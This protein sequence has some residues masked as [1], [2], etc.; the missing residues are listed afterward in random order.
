[1]VTFFFYK[2]FTTAEML[3]K[4]S[5]NYQYSDGYVIVEDF[6]LDQD[7]VIINKDSKPN[8]KLLHGKIVQ[9]PSSA[10]DVVKKIQE[11]AVGV[12]PKYIMESVWANKST[13]GVQKAFIIY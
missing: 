13:G 5:S 11:C 9:F 7:I 6:H 3:S 1:M 4:I 12:K 10:T 8:N 2:N